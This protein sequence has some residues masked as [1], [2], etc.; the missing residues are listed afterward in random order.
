MS[1]KSSK[2]PSFTSVLGSSTSSKLGRGKFCGWISRPAHLPVLPP[3]N[4][5]VPLMRSSSPHALWKASYFLTLVF[6]SS[7][8]ISRALL[9]SGLNLP[10]RRSF[11][12]SLFKL[13]T[14]CP[15]WSRIHFFSCATLCGFS[16]PVMYLASSMSAIP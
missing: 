7:C 13:S 16:S 6:P 4:W 8:R 2:L 9:V 5:K 3:K 11:T 14:S 15:S 10:F 12:A 1:S